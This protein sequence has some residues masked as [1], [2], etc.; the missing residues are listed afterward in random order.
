VAELLIH[1]FQEAPNILVVV[2][3]RLRD[4][5]PAHIKGAAYWGPSEVGPGGPYRIP[6]GD[7]NYPLPEEFIND[8]WYAL[9]L[10]DCRYKTVPEHKLARGE[11]GLDWWHDE[12]EQHPTNWRNR[13]L[14]QPRE[15]WIIDEEDSSNSKPEAD[16][17]SPPPDY[18]RRT[19]TAESRREMDLLAELTEL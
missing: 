6:F 12:D 1:I 2:P 15:T 11:L 4:N 19:P 14:M 16:P 13:E 8:N 9:T 5:L 17:P 18:R 3:V 10:E 7:N